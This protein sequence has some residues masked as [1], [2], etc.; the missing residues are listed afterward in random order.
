MGIIFV[1]GHIIRERR[2]PVTEEKQQHFITMDKNVSIISI[3]DSDTSAC[4]A[5]LNETFSPKKD[6]KQSVPVTPKREPVELDATYTPEDKEEASP[7]NVQNETFS[8]VKEATPPPPPS[9]A[10]ANRRTPK[11]QLPESCS[12]FESPRPTAVPDI[13][14]VPPTAERRPLRRSVRTPSK[15]TVE[16]VATRAST[17]RSTRQTPI[18]AA[19]PVV[20]EKKRGRRSK[21]DLDAT[22]ESAVP[23]AVAIIE[24]AHVEEEPMAIAEE[25]DEAADKTI[26]LLKEIEEEVAPKKMKKEEVVK[27]VQPSPVDEET[28]TTQSMATEE[29]ND[30]EKLTEDE[31]DTA[32]DEEENSMEITQEVHAPIFAS[33]FLLP[34]SIRKRSLSVTDVPAAIPKRNF[35]VQFHSPGN[36]EKTITEIDES[37]YLN[38][39][40]SFASSFSIPA[41]PAAKEESAKRKPLR[42]KRSLSNAE[43]PVE[44]LATIQL[45]C[46]KAKKDTAPGSEKK[47]L[48]TPSPRKKMPN[49]AA[50]HQNIFQQMESL[51]DFKERKKERAQFLLTAVSPAAPLTLAAKA[52][53]VKPGRLT[54]FYFIFNEYFSY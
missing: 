40:K 31:D 27:E 38:F 2:A 25:E 47:K 24:D 4:G 35:R 36:M 42:R 28:A 46:D 39:T 22:V 6:A 45:M 41:V 43:T 15:P 54:H 7:K 26:E 9:S 16:P 53:I 29:R 44:K 49:F 14:V 50:I 30:N 8:P 52:S 5:G 19:T 33:E 13:V 48:P 23:E 34:K 17:R 37:L 51:V 1:V 12:S 18:K 11:R 20:V 32:A 3:P 21:K 10:R